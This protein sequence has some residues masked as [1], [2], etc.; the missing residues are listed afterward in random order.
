MIN[1][2]P[3]EKVFQLKGSDHAPFFSRP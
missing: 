1:S 3:P 2:N